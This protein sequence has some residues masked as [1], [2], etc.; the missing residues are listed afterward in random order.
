MQ[1]PGSQPRRAHS[2]SCQLLRYEKGGAITQITVLSSL[3]FVQLVFFSFNAF[4]FVC[5]AEFS[6]LVDVTSERG[7]HLSAV[8]EDGLSSVYQFAISSANT[9]PTD[10]GECKWLMPSELASNK[11]WRCSE[12]HVCDSVPHVIKLFYCAPR[13]A[14]TAAFPSNRGV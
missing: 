1:L 13:S 14:Q 9:Q 7:C 2:G 4:L 6:V 8:G 12:L 10:R 5:A 11:S 3:E